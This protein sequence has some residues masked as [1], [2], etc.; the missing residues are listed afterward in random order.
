MLPIDDPAVL[1]LLYHLNSEPWLNLAA[2]IQPPAD[3]SIEPVAA[4]LRPLPPIEKPS[5]LQQIMLG[6]R[7][8]RAFDPQRRLDAAN[9]GSILRC[10]YGAARSPGLPVMLTR[11]IPSAGA[12][13]PL[14]LFAS[15]QRVAALMDGLYAYRPISH[16][17]APLGGTVP[18]ELGRLL[19]DQPFVET[20][21]VALFFAADLGRTAGKYGARGY[22]YLL[23]E[24]GHAAQ[25]ACLV[26]AEEGLATICIGGFFDSQV[27][28]ILGIED[29]TILLLYCLLIGWAADRPS[30][31]ISQRE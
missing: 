5:A 8:C 1:P 4:D 25:N 10:C 12:L 28:T 6:R 21:N 20:A 29:G 18:A 9:L 2:Y 27:R 11:P 26:A 13:Y 23:L 15:V 14:T 16:A 3:R 31:T 19:L 22:R 17:L 30:T 7:S 24:A